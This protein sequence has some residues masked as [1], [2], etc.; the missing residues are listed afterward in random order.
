MIR[1]ETATIL[2]KSVNN[3]IP[4]YR[5][6]LFIRNSDRNTINL[7]N[8]ETDLLVPFM[9]TSNVQKAF[10]FRGAKTWNEHSREAKHAA[11]LS[12]VKNKIKS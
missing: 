11:S 10:A 12:F 7:R 9:K 5:S 4:E 6:H 2:F 3:L 1:C 8:A